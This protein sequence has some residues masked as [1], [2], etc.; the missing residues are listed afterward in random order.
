MC[1]L[2][3][4]CFLL[5]VPMIYPES[6]QAPTL[7]VKKWRC[8][9]RRDLGLFG[10]DQKSHQKEEHRYMQNITLNQ[11]FNLHFHGVSGHPSGNINY[12]GLSESRVLLD[13]LWFTISVSTKPDTYI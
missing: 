12:F 2:V 3:P 5:P 4:Y 9:V 1:V 13:S 6:N 10:A 11:A 8:W 7:G